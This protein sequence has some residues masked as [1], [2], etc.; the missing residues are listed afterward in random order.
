[1]KATFLV[2]FVT[3]ILATWGLIAEQDDSSTKKVQEPSIDGTHDKVPLLDQKQISSE[4]AAR[5][6]YGKTEQ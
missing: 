2:G 6:F 1:V 5:K 3:L 4:E